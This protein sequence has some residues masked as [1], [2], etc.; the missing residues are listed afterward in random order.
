MKLPLLLSIAILGSIVSCTKVY[1]PSTSPSDTTNQVTHT[2]KDVIE[3]RV[4][5]NATI[6]RVRYSDSL[7][8]LNQVN[9]ILPFNS[10]FTSTRDSIFLSLEA[11]PLSY[12][13]TIFSPFLSVQ[14]FVNG[15]LF[16]EASSSDFL[17]NTISVSGV[18]R[19]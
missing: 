18:Y 14:I 19:H 10:E 1:V 3:F 16:K 17:L 15:T 12:Q 13:Y 4:N 2:S 8:G 5:G 9:T 6:A 7:G 11:T